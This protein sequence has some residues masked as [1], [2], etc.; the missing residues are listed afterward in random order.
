M[1]ASQRASQLESFALQESA[2]A[3]KKC[4]FLCL[5]SNV[6]TDINGNNGHNGNTGGNSGLV[7]LM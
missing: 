4:S 3:S 7:I 2:V 5:G 6:H 1:L